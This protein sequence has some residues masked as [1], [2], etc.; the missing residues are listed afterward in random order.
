MIWH[1]D[2]P[3]LTKNFRPA[4][5][6][7]KP[8]DPILNFSFFKNSYGRVSMTFAEYK[9]DKQSEGQNS[10]DHMSYARCSLKLRS[11]QG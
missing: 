11:F 7:S 1:L 9:K 10:A 8:N 5:T 2:C 4:E 6:K 3:K